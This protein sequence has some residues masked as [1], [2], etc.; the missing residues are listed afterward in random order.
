[1][2]ASGNIHQVI[3]K[4]SF[5]AAKIVENYNAFMDAIKACK[6][7]SHKGQLVANISMCSTM[8]PAVKIK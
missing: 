1:M 2:D 3:G 4:A 5:D 7:D 6:N 8:S